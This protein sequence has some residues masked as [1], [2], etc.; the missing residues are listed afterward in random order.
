[1]KHATCLTLYPALAILSATPLFAQEPVGTGPRGEQHP[2]RE[3]RLPNFVKAQLGSR[4]VVS[5]ESDQRLGVVRDHVIDRRTGKIL[6]I[7]VGTAREGG[8][9]YLV[10]FR[11]FTFD[12]ESKSLSLAKSLEELAAMPLY[13]PA[14][15]NSAERLGMTDGSESAQGEAREAAAGQGRLNLAS[16]VILGSR[17]GAGTDPFGSVGELILNADRG[18]VAFALAKTE[19]AG[20]DPLVIPW[21]AMQWQD[22]RDGKGHF[23]VRIPGDDPSIAPTLERGDASQLQDE[24]TLSSIYGFYGITAPP[25]SM[26]GGEARG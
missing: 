20:G 21:A 3:L 12:A 23:L 15:F 18:T 14:T 7:A 4:A 6:S 16:S 10:P 25:V 26:K 13:D 19:I 9:M 17:I 2:E 5:E 24:G 22:A 11:E 8:D 1:M